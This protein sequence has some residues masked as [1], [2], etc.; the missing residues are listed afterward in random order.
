MNIAMEFVKKAEGL[1]LEAYRDS[2][3][4]LTVG[5]GHVDASITAGMKITKAQADAYLEE[6]M[7]WA[8][9]EV[10]RD[11]TVSISEE[12]EAA[13]ISLT[14]NIGVGAFRNSTVLRRLN[15]GDTEGAADAIL[16]WN[17]ITV[18]GKK[19]IS[20]GLVNRRNK[21]R[22]LFLSSVDAVSLTGR[23]TGGEA[24]PMNKSKTMIASLTG[25]ATLGG[26]VLPS[27]GTMDWRVALP[28]IAIGGL[29][30]YLAFN[31]WLE[32]RRGVH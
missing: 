1:R 24:K 3:G 4:I 22:A 16:M 18:N 5:Y 21:E 9:A 23:A 28:L 7:G 15:S 11:V 2:A 27:F 31:R 12:Q 6:D 13:L 17:K 8:V 32:S 30:A 26:A 14:F 10:K 25:L 20:Q 29:F 19:E